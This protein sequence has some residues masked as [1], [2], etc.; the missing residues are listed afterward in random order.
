MKREDREDREE[1]FVEEGLK[2]PHPTVDFFFS[3]GW[4]ILVVLVIIGALWYFAYTI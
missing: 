4:A 2:N 1:Y 3:Y